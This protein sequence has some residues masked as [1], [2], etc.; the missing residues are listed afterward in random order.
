MGRAAISK[1]ERGVIDMWVAD[2][3]FKTDPKIVEAFRYAVRH[4]CTHYFPAPGFDPNVFQKAVAKHYRRARGCTIDPLTEIVPTHGA[5]EALSLS[6]QA[7]ARP[8]DEVL[9]PEPTYNVFIE[10]LEGF[11]VKPVLVP[12]L[13]KE[14]WRIDFDSVKSAITGKTR[15]IFICNPNN[16]T[17][18]LCGSKDMEELSDILTENRNV[19]VIL[20]ECY[21][22]M[23]YGG[24]EHHSLLG[25]RE[26]MD[27]VYVVNSFSKTY[28]MTGWRLG[29]VVAARKNA[30]RI[31]Q[32]SFEYNGGVAYSVQYAGAV[33]LEKCSGSV[34]KM[35]A[36]LRM[37]RD[38]MLAGLRELKDVAFVTPDGGF[39]VFADFSSYT[40]DSESFVRALEDEARV[41]TMPGR[42]YGPSG[43][44]HVRFVFCS[45]TAERIREGTS[46][47]GAWLE[48]Q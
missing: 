44:G 7:A 18:T 20:D 31:K 14:R 15:L 4:G 30:D 43:E 16:P 34:R 29:Y 28:A 46:R 35:H 5:Q 11:G 6:V 9:I 37:R 38:A 1:K 42:K 13:E 19:S 40:S 39:E 25:E 47:V 24:A 26:L 10:K 45:N 3:A 21:S 48:D 22:R 32:I 36:E 2:P 41:K 12:L 17:G 27:Q 23:L 33:A 8:G